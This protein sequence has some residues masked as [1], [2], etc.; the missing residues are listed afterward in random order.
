[1]VKLVRHTKGSRIMATF[2]P[3]EGQVMHIAAFADGDWACGDMDRKSVSGF[4]IMVAGCR[5]SSHSTDTS[6]PP[7]VQVRM[8]S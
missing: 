3:A 1:M 2:L 5:M 4:I 6:E 8:R 7:S